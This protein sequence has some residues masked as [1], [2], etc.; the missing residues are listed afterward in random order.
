[1]G[2]DRHQENGRLVFPCLSCLW[3]DR[4]TRKTQRHHVSPRQCTFLPGDEKGLPEM[5]SIFTET[6][7]RLPKTLFWSP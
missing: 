5:F 1:M 6:Y 3:G 4:K 7:F 2:G